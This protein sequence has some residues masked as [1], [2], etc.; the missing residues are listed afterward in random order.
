MLVARQ[1]KHPVYEFLN[2]S[3]KNSLASGPIIEYRRDFQQKA[4]FFRHNLRKLPTGNVTRCELKVRRQEI[5]GD[6][7]DK[8]MAK[9]D[10]TVLRSKLWI[11]FLGEKG[12]DYGGVAREWFFL[13]SKEMFNPYHGLFEYSSVDNYTLQINP[14][15][16]TFQENHLK[17][18]EFI[19]R[20][21]G[22]AVYH[23]K[24]LDAFFVRPFYKMMLK[25][26]ITIRDMEAVDPEFYNSLM[27]IKKNDPEPLC[28]TFSQ[29]D[30]YL[31]TQDLIP[32]GRNIE[33]TN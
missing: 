4:T 33:V 30:E 23:G 16:G 2:F 1:Q 13:L 32:D 6:S 14:N 27:Y 21:A 8:L 20:V 18:F 24:L 11:E 19:G 28:L 10:V 15:S 29:E 26:N 22:M 31:G 7:F 17:Y 25:K 12:L 5:F 9:K 3:I